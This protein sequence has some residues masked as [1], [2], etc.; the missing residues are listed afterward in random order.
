MIYSR[1]WQVFYLKNF[2][3]YFIPL[4]SQT[5]KKEIAEAISQSADFVSRLSEF[6]K[7]LEA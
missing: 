2:G 4:A 7:P 3:V 1:L 6:E 5:I